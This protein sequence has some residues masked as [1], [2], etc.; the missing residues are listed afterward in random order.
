MELV[1]KKEILDDDI[2]F[3]KE[4]E[5]IVGVLVDPRGVNDV[6]SDNLSLVQNVRLDQF[7][8]KK[9][10]VWQIASRSKIGGKE[11]DPGLVF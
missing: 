10:L 5:L 7:Q 11:N 3:G 1:P 4:K 6:Y 2:P 8:G 9:W